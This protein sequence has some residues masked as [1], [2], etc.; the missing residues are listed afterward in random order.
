MG[1]R[2]PIAQWLDEVG[3][4]GLRSYEKFVPDGIFHVSKA[5]IALFLRHI[6]ATDGSV[7]VSKSGRGGRVYYAS[8][9]RRL[10]DDLSLL[11]LR[12]GISTRVR[13]THKAGYRD[14]F[15]LDISGADSQRRFLQEIGVH[16]SRGVA[17]ERL[18]ASSATPRPTP[19]STRCPSRCGTPSRR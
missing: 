8:T 10:V 2:N 16:G 14:G 15:T 3:V 11:L 9:S 19:T 13:I 18:L 7:T 12:F 5:Q 17:A 6:W 4:F 1:V